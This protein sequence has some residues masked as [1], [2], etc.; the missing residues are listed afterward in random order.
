M[1]YRLTDFDPGTR[2]SDVYAAFRQEN[3]DGSYSTYTCRWSPRRGGSGSGK[4]A[5]AYLQNCF[6]NPDAVALHFTNSKLRCHELASL[7]PEAP[8]IARRFARGSRV[9]CHVNRR[10]GK[11]VIT[12][13]FDPD[14]AETFCDP[15]VS[16]NHMRMQ[17]QTFSL[18]RFVAL[19]VPLFSQTVTGHLDCLVCDEERDMMYAI[20]IKS[21][22]SDH[23]DPWA[24]TA[25]SIL[26]RNLVQALAYCELLS[27]TIGSSRVAVGLLHRDGMIVLDARDWFAQGRT[28]LNG[29]RRHLESI[30]VRHRTSRPCP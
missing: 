16:D 9:L 19:E 3:S 27:Q 20:E 25:R 22:P 12:E 30:R 8:Y 17:L 10:R 5:S 2:R 4:A 24:G 13:M 7:V 11:R 14:L 1:Q 18:D 26:Y 21:Y 23:T 15:E 29:V 6:E 28:L